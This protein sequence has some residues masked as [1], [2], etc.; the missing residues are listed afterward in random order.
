MNRF[1]TWNNNILEFLIIVKKTILNMLCFWFIFYVGRKAY[2]IVF[3]SLAKQLLCCI[4]EDTLRVKS[5]SKKSHLLCLYISSLYA[6]TFF[7]KKF[8][9]SSFFVLK[10]SKKDRKINNCVDLSTTT[11]TAPDIQTI[12][13][14]SREMLQ[15][16]V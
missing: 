1:L 7:G 6:C 4:N 5:F 2:S 16:A 8:F 15:K 14:W 10:K 9:H 13:Q 12:I 3:F 11:E